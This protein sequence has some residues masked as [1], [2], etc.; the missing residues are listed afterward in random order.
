MTLTFSEKR[1]FSVIFPCNNFEM[2]SDGCDHTAAQGTQAGGEFF[3]PPYYSMP[4]VATDQSTLGKNC[5]LLNYSL[6]KKGF[7]PL[8]YEFDFFY[9]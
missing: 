3:P 6:Y 5:N 4:C 1:L 2:E 7:F 8:S 9:R